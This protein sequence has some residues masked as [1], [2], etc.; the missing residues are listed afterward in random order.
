MAGVGYHGG[1]TKSTRSLTIV[2]LVITFSAIMLLVADLDR[3]QEGF[4]RVGQQPM[5]DLRNM[6]ND[7][8]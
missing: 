4:M 1:L 8:R 2:V 7:S 6:M 5:I 3:P